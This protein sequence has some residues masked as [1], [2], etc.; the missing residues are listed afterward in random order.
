[1]KRRKTTLRLGT[2]GS[3][4]ARTQSLWVAEQLTTRNPNLEIELVICTTTGDKVQDKPLYNFGGKGCFT[5][6]L[7][8]WI[9]DGRVDFAV[10]SFKDVP[11]TMPLTDVSQ[12]CIAAI[13]RREDPRDV[14]VAKTRTTIEEL[15]YG[16]KV[17]TGSLR[18]RCQLLALRPDLNVQLIRGNIDTRLAKLEHGDFDAVVLA[19]AGLRR[20]GLNDR[21][22]MCAIPV[23]QMLPAAAQ[24]A[25]ALQCRDNDDRAKHILASLHDPM[26]ALCVD[27][28]REIIEFLE[29][30]CHSPI[31]ALAKVNDQHLHV[32][33]VV[34]ARGGSLPIVKAE[35]TANYCHPIEAIDQIVRQL[36]D[37]NAKQLLHTPRT[38]RVSA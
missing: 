14:L 32:K 28:E 8:E 23:D 11:V 4:L 2:R 21:E 5:K 22:H 33:A 12:L 37:L 30:D 13:P 9:L 6:E 27:I 17:G 7:E 26:T 29:G 36:S 18:R 31:A 35:C 10:H 19:L 16:A 25:L 15:P 24:G 38:E 34:G 3:R 1:M 20:C